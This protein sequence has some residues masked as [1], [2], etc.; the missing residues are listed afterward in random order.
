M[1]LLTDPVNE[2]NVI[3]RYK[4]FM[5]TAWQGVAWGTNN[6]PI[7]AVGTPYATEVIT[8]ASMGG[9]TFDNPGDFAFIGKLDGTIADPG[10]LI[11]AERIHTYL[12][13][14]TFEH[15]KVRKLRVLLTI[16]GTG[17]NTGNY[18]DPGNVYDVTAIA[19]L[20]FRAFQ[21]GLNVDYVTPASG[22]VAGGQV[23]SALELQYFM[24][25]CLQA[26]NNFARNQTYIFNPII[27]HASCHSSCHGSRGRR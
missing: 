5:Y 12:N 21:P 14:F 24:E 25:R 15:C 17:G 22:G 7:Y 3:S 20:N 9:S 27:C 23:I 18:P 10:S 2:R 19:H 11:T 6:V 4:D 13:Y 16:T 8:R 26:Y 1:A